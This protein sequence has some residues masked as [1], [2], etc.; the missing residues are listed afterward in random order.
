[1]DCTQLTPELSRAA[2]RRR[3]EGIVRQPL[4][5]MQHSHS[6][7]E[8]TEMNCAIHQAQCWHGLRAVATIFPAGGVQA[9]SG[10]HGACGRGFESVGMRAT[11]NRRTPSGKD[12]IPAL[13]N[14]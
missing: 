9:A 14:A 7:V 3:L 1:M 11:S 10:L 8:L 4:A 6:P 5:E 2:K 12:L 13:P